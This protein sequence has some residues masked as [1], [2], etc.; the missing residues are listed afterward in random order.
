MESIA[1]YVET[2]RSDYEVERPLKSLAVFHKIGIDAQE[3]CHF[4]PFKVDNRR[5]RQA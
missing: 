2:N 3:W 1:N 4:R 5:D